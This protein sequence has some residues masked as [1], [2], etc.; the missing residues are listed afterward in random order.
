MEPRDANALNRPAI[1]RGVETYIREGYSTLDPDCCD[2]ASFTDTRHITRR[3][4]PR[5]NRDRLG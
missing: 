2:Y 1:M 3:D 4:Y 5:T